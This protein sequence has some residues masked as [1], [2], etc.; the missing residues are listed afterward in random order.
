[1]RKDLLWLC[2]LKAQSKRQWVCILLSLASQQSKP[3]LLEGVHVCLSE[4]SHGPC[5]ACAVEGEAHTPSWVLL[6]STSE[7]RVK[8]RSTG[9]ALWAPRWN[10]PLGAG[11]SSLLLVTLTEPVEFQKS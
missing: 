3:Q 4:V 6:A 9:K 1:M 8:P 10:F 5:R 7:N 2:V 11:P